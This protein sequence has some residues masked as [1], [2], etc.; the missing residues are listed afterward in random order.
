ME[1][2]EHKLYTH[3]TDK[4]DA[5]AVAWAFTNKD[6]FVEFPFK[7]QD[8]VA[9][10]EIRANVL[11]AG[12]CLSDSLH[13]RSKW[14]PSP[15]PIAPGHE[16]IAEVSQIGSD[17]K[18]FKVGDKVAF[19]TLREICN[20]CKYCNKGLGEP[21]CEGAPD[22]F[23]YGK[24]FGGFSS[25]I[26]QPADFFIRI[27]DGLILEKSAPLLCAGITVYNPIKKYLKA[28]DNTAVFGVGGLGHLAVQFLSKMGHQCT[29]VT[30]TVS[31]KD[32]IL[33]LG[34]TD[35]INSS[36]PE[37]M[38]ANA[39]RFDFIIDTIP[40]TEN[41]QARFNL[42]A[43]GGTYV[44]VGVGDASASTLGVSA[45]SVVIGERKLVGSLVGNRETTKEMLE[46]CV[47]NDVYP[48]VEEFKF[49]DFPKALD[50]LENGKPVFRCVVNTGEY[51]KKNGLFK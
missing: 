24:H 16:T 1:S 21:L 15:Y 40:S 7:F 51:T 12:L 39:D 6:T 46:F 27:P 20:S 26:Q 5:D 48:I 25:Q 2:Y 14:G 10:H 11:Y 42:L 35:I 23:S 18:D 43:P 37:E 29:G 41:F 33:S 8:A 36:D 38:K 34:A 9:P 47:K 28:G 17:V 49:E 32:F 4:K 13:S 44:L 30:T 31:K 45:F 3:V 50:K 22:K 19:G